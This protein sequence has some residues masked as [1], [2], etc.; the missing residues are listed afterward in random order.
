MIQQQ[1]NARVDKIITRLKNNIFVSTIVSDKLTV[2]STRMRHIYIKPKIH[3]RGKPGRPAITSV[4]CHMYKI[5]EDVDFHIQPTVYWIYPLY[6]K[7]NEFLWEL[8]TFA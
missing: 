3:N 7:D 8:Q 1:N 6:V 4:N 5:S 2:E